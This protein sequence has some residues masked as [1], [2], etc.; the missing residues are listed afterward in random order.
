M[1]KL[2]QGVVNFHLNVLPG[3]VQQF[4]KLAHGQ[5]PDALMIACFDSR[6]APN[7]FAS[8]DPGDLA[9][10]RNPG[11]LVPPA[12]RAGGDPNRES[13]AAAIEIALERLNVKDIIV[14]GHSGCAGM[15]ALLDENGSPSSLKEWIRHGHEAKRRL[16]AGLTLDPSLTLQDQLSQLNVLVQLENLKTYP[17]LKERLVAGALRL[18]GWWFDIATGNVYNFE[19]E[20][21]RFI[22]I[23]EKEGAKILQRLGA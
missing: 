5:S 20:D 13:E 9:V 18:H 19:S 23:D 7:V 4:A 6:V 1:L 17:I 12:P 16:D 10:V 14:C 21:N 22:V 11:N 15:A 3:M 8:T 2:V